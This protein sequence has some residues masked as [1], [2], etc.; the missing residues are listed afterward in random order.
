MNRRDFLKTTV[1]MA[2]LAPFASLADA[3]AKGSAPAAAMTR[4]T[5]KSGISLPLLGFGGMRLPRRK[6]SAEIDV[7]EVRR[8][9]ACAM[10]GGCNYFDTA[11]MYHGRSEERRV[12]KEC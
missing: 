12:G 11:F 2:A 8:M 7:D 3:L 10:E 6:S 5:L 1:T 4:R 9:V